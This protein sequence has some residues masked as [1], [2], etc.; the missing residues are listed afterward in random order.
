MWISRGGGPSPDNELMHSTL[1]VGAF[2]VRKIKVRLAGQWSFR[3]EFRSLP[4]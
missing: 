1:V 4:T 3:P 2:R